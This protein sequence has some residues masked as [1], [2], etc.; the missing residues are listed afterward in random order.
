MN[1]N[2]K[3]RIIGYHNLLSSKHTS[4]R[5][6]THRQLEYKPFFVDGTIADTSASFMRG[7]HHHSGKEW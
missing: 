1:Y 3:P 5:L 7:V 6:R 2:N 4:H